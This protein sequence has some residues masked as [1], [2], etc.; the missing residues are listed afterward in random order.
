[1]VPELGINGYS[2]TYYLA[3]DQSILPSE[4]S[5]EKVKIVLKRL[6]CDWEIAIESLENGNVA[7]LPF[8]FS[9]ETVNSLKVM[10][11]G[12]NLL[13]RHTWIRTYGGSYVSNIQKGKDEE[14]NVYIGKMVVPIEQF[15]SDIRRERDRV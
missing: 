7:Y 10:R 8:D 14:Y 12:D 15:L 1:M 4:E 3:L 2:D 13:I 9:D 5:A 6:L 11:M